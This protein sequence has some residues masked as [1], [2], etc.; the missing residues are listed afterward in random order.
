M[1][2]P[3]EM[4]KMTELVCNILPSDT[5]RYLMGVGL[6]ENILESIALGIDMFDCCF[7][8]CTSRYFIHKKWHN[9]YEKFQVAR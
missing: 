9:E 4:Y 6:P 1:E 8:K 2:E 3:Q 7:Q 5:P